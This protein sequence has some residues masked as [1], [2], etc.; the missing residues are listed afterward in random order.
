MTICAL[1]NYW[2]Q[3]WWWWRWWWWWG[4]TCWRKAGFCVEKKSKVWRRQVD[5][6]VPRRRRGMY[7][8][9]GFCLLQFVTTT[10][11]QVKR[12][13]IHRHKQTDRETVALALAPV[14]LVTRAPCSGTWQIAGQNWKPISYLTAPTLTASH[15][16][17]WR[18]FKYLF[19]ECDRFGLWK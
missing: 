17:C 3:I 5:K 10:N 11:E 16:L 4:S 7:R 6:S 9:L 12:P 18:P 19:A 14:A 13:N 8:L 1:W 2:R 15:L